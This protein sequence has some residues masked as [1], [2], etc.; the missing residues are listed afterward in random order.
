[1]IAMIG[2]S[3]AANGSSVAQYNATICGHKAETSNAG[4]PVMALAPIGGWLLWRDQRT[5]NTEMP[6]RS[7]RI[8]PFEP[9][10]RWLRGVDHLAS[11][12]CRNLRPRARPRVPT[13]RTACPRGPGQVL[14]VPRVAAPAVPRRCR[15][16]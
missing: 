7:G 3:P 4:E 15:R 6:S 9:L 2:G 11:R 13:E 14:A 12:W 8:G 1:M 5:T 10:R 16:G